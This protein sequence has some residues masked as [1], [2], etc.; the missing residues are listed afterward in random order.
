MKQCQALFHPRAQSQRERPGARVASP[1]MLPRNTE[2]MLA[3]LRDDEVVLDVGAWGAPF[4]RADWVL[5][6]MPYETR[7]PMGSYGPGPERFNEERWVI[8][9]FCDREPWPWPDD[10]F[11][12][13]L[14]VTT[15]EDIRDPVWVCS[16]LS[17]V[18]KR[19]YIEVPTLISELAY[20]GQGPWCGFEHHRWL[21]WVRDGGIE[22]MHKPHS[23][24]SDWRVRVPPRHAAKM[25]EEDHLQPLFWEGEL[26]AHERV[27]VGPY[28]LGELEEQVRAVLQPSALEIRAKEARD[29]LWD[30]RNSAMKPVRSARDALL[31]RLARK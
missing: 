27:V 7:G 4:N 21:C 10:F 29:R 23:I 28:P 20:G 31:R 2:K 9:D 5:D 6:A 11:D 19:G 25:T 14:C 15:L 16:E 26:P 8:R 13:S 30:A 18:S 17:R 3:E 24:H 1:P 12:F 22:F